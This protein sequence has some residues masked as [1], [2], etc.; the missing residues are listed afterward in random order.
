M[1]TE[2]HLWVNLADIGKKEKCFLL[3]APVLPSEL[4][5]TSVEVMVE[6]FREVKVCSAAF[7]TFISQRSRSKPE[8]HRGPG[9]SESE[10]QRRA[11][12]A[13]VATRTPPPSAGGVKRKRKSKG[14]RQDQREVIQRCSQHSRLDQSKT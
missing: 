7:K 13:S 8:Q 4:F 10:D 12:M 5:S 6:K 3:D 9:P 2:R 14:G 11:Q 1:V